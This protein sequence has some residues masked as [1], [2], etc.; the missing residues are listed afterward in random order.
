LWETND[1]ARIWRWFSN[2]FLNAFIRLVNSAPITRL[3]P[4]IVSKQIKCWFKR[5]LDHFEFAG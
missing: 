3:K 2:H 1:G 5:A 4:G